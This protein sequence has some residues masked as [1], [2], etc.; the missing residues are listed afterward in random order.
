MYDIAIIGSGPAGVSAAL[1]LKVLGKNFI[2]FSSRAVSKKVEKAELIKNYPGLPDVT[3]GELAASL[4]TH[5]EKM[6]IPLTEEVVTGIYDTGG[7]FTL[8]AKDKQYEAQA[9]I[10]RLDAEA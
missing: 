4:K 5:F 9:V 7:K 3:G 8:L 10:L 6:D 1:N 2:W